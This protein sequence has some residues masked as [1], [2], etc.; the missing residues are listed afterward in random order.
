ME[1]I[2]ASVA[3][4]IAL[5]SS[6][7]VTASS[8]WADLEWIRRITAEEIA[9]LKQAAVRGDADSSYKLSAVYGY[10]DSYSFIN[11]F[12][13]LRLAAEQG[14]CRAILEFDS[15]QK[16]K[17]LS[18]DFVVPEKMEMQVRRC[19]SESRKRTGLK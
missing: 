19:R 7:S 4:A 14:D 2:L 17:T 5:G 9:T 18:S 13:Y 12:F 16:R 6:C 15:L 11:Y 3:L 1:K 10:H 8:N